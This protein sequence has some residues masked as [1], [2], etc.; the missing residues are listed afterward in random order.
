MKA[1]RSPSNRRRSSSP[2]VDEVLSVEGEAAAAHREAAGEIAGDDAAE[3]ALAR[4]GLADEA[5]DA[6]ALQR[7]RHVA[8]HLHAAE[9]RR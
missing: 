4:A 2:M 6:A 8:Q 5:E 1:M 9:A 7:E 3:H